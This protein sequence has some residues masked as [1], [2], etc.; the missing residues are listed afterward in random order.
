MLTVQYKDTK[1]INIIE[2]NN[3]YCRK[4]TQKMYTFVSCN[5]QDDT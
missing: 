2:H 5:G 1:L 4:V 3:I